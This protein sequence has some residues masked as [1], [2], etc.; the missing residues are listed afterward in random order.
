M[1]T[2]AKGRKAEKE[3]KEIMTDQGFIC[4][5]V[6]PSNK[7]GAVDFFG[8]ADIIGLH[9]TGTYLVQ[10]KSNRT[11]GAIKKMTDWYNKNMIYLPDNIHLQVVVRKD[12]VSIQ[13][14]WR[15]IDVV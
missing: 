3:Y 11:D 9:A 15:V 10:V 2:K 6:K 7:F 5:L 13:E 12:G 4:E 1:N 8:I 14:R